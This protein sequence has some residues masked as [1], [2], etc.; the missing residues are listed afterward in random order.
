M[1]S[2]ETISINTKCIYLYNAYVMALENMPTTRT[3]GQCCG[4]AIEKLHGVGI[5]TTTSEQTLT[6]WHR[7]FRR[8]RKFAHPHSK[9][10]YSPLLLEIFPEA[11]NIICEWAGKDLNSL[12]SETLAMFVRREIAAKIHEQLPDEHGLTLDE[13]TN[14]LNL[15]NFGVSTAYRYL[16]H[17]GFK[18]CDRKRTYYNDK[19]ESEENI[20]DR[21]EFIE[22]YKEFEKR[23]HL[24]VQISDAE[25]VDL[26]QQHGLLPDTAAYS[27]NGMREYHIDTHPKFKEMQASP[28]VRIPPALDHYIFMVKMKQCTNNTHLGANVGMIAGGLPNYCQKVMACQ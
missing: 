20:K 25:A 3:W 22:K 23:A 1:N 21:L 19:H 28:S 14:S 16:G 5:T 13:F 7:E 6:L 24:W 27:Y 17:L 18:W 26:E 15:A 12:S 11:K 4:D 10:N 2:A 8:S 9:K